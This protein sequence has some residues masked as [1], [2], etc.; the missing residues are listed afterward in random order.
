MGPANADDIPIHV[1][2]MLK[3]EHAGGDAGMQT[4]TVSQVATK[5]Q[6]ATKMQVA[7]QTCTTVVCLETTPR[8]LFAQLP[9]RQLV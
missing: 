5:T 2:S 4:Q 3:K 1:K 8:Q 9:P 6:V 7:T